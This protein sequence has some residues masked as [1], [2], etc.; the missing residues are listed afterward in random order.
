[1]SKTTFI[2]VLKDP[3]T[4]ECR[5]VGKA[6]NPKKRLAVHFAKSLKPKTHLQTWIKHLLSLGLRPTL[7]ILEEVPESQW[8]FWE[9]EYIRVFRLIG[10]NLTNGTDGGEGSHNPTPEVKAKQS[11]S[12]LGRAKPPFT[13]AHK[14]AIRLSRLGTK[15]TPETRK[16]MSEAHAGEKNSFFGRVHSEETLKKLSLAHT[17]KKFIRSPEYRLGLSIRKKAWWAA[18]KVVEIFQPTV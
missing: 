4:G 6:N 18:R 5:Y 13:E 10:F 1:M 2:Y 17:G 11:N 7:E 12:L 9:R 3:R 8:A 15:A 16:K 14:E